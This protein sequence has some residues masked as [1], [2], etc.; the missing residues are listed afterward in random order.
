MHKLI[1]PALVVMLYANSS[2]QALAHTG[3]MTKLRQQAASILLASSILLAPLL[4]PALGHAQGNAEDLQA[5]PDL[6]KVISI[7][8]DYQKGALLLHISNEVDGWN[9]AFHTAFIGTDKDGNALL[10]ARRNPALFDMVFLLA[11]PNITVN[12]YG[13]KGLIDKDIPLE[14]VELAR[15]KTD[16]S[17][18]MAILAAD[19]KLNN[20]N[21]PNMQMTEFPFKDEEDVELLTY[22]PNNIL[23]RLRAAELQQLEFG[24]LSLFARSCIT[25]PNAELTKIGLSTTTCGLV[26]GAVAIGSPIVNAEGKLIGFHSG[27]TP[28]EAWWVSATTRRL[29]VTASRLTSGASPVDLS[30]KMATTWGAI[31]NKH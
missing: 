18:D 3:G 26:D 14:V 1:T 7:S 27:N 19:V 17:F 10:V 20:K 23:P 29:R 5:H 12:L 15:D 24:R 21:Y 28:I 2:S 22:L 30:N 8:P 31:K 25:V 9:L 6:K 16:G 11:Q 13:W 4:A